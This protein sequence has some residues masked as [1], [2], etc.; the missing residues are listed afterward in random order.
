MQKILLSIFMVVASTAA[1]AATNTLSPA[2]ISRATTGSFRQLP[3]AAGKPAIEIVPAD[4]AAEDNAMEEFDFTLSYSPYTITAMRNAVGVEIIQAF[5]ISA[6]L[7]TTYAGATIKSINFFNPINSSSEVN[8]IPTATLYMF[9]KIGGST[10]MSQEVDL[11]SDGAVYHR[12]ALDTPYTIEAGKSIAI[13]FGITPVSDDDYYITVDGLATDTPGGCYIGVVQDNQILWNNASMDVGNI[14]MG[15][16][17]EAAG[18]PQNGVSL[19][20]VEVPD[21]AVLDTPFTALLYIVGETPTSVNEVE[22]EYTLGDGNVNSVVWN[23]PNPFNYHDIVGGPITDLILS[24]VG[25][26]TLTFTVTKVN[27]QPNTSS[28]ASRSVVVNCV[29]PNIG[30]F[31]N[32]VVEEGTGTWCGFCPSGMVFME[33]MK[34]EY[35]DIIRIAIHSN[36]QMLVSSSS[37]LMQMF[38]SFP[39]IYINRALKIIP[40]ESDTYSKFDNYYENHIGIPALMEVTALDIEPISDRQMRIKAK[41]R[42]AIDTNNDNNRYGIAFS[43]TEDGMGP[44]LQTNNYAGNRYGEMG[45]WERKGTAVPTVYDDVLRVY[46]GG[47]GGFTK[48]FP[49]QIKA[50]EEYEFETIVYNT[51][52]NSE[53]FFLNALIIDNTTGEIAN[54]KQVATSKS[55]VQALSEDTARIAAEE[56]YNLNGIRVENPSEGIFIKRVV[57]TDGSEFHTKIHRSR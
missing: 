42:F 51:S 19:Y 3:L 1:T 14:C 34:D 11:G 43:I 57:F 6:E 39:Q 48:I 38:N 26:H 50:Q 15:V 13:G 36:D 9:D 2:K 29:D 7:A 31:R 41:A 40:S 12:Y 16:T 17:L 30:Y 5:E 24:E 56:Y 22:I 32:F 20:S 21:N 25:T 10:I 52:I 49:A 27:G 45:G 35:P 44:Y 54:A 18:F 23:S 8:D 47:F 55:A 33:T 28:G 46:A 37:V 4:A 53:E